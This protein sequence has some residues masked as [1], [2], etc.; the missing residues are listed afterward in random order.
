MGYSTGGHGKARSLDVLSHPQ[1]HRPAPRVTLRYYSI[2]LVSLPVSIGRGFA[3]AD[4]A[5]SFRSIESRDQLAQYCGVPLHTL[6]MF[7]YADHISFYRD[8]FVQK[9][10]GLGRRRIS[11]PVASLKRIQRTIMGG[12]KESYRPLS[13]VYG[14]VD[15][16]NV[17]QN[18]LMH[19]KKK[20][21][22]TLDLEDFFPSITS[23]RVYGL[24]NKFLGFNSE[25]SSTLTGLV[26]H[27]GVLPQGAPTSPIISN[28]ICYKMDKALL[29]YCAAH[30][31]TYSRYADDLIFSST[32]SYSM[33]CLL[34]RSE[35]RPASLSA[36][37]VETITNNGFKINQNKTHIAN[38]GSRQLVNGIVVNVK[39]NMLRSEYRS[40]RAMFHIWEKCGYFQAVKKYLRAKPQYRDKLLFDGEI[41]S[42]S[43]FIRHI[44]GRLDYYSLVVGSNGRP[45][46]PMIKLWTMFYLQTGEKVPYVT[47]EMSS[48]LITYVYD[49]VAPSSGEIATCG[50]DASAVLCRGFILTCRHCIPQDHTDA[51]GNPVQVEIRLPN[52][53]GASVNSGSFKSY[54]GFDF[55]YA[56]LNGCDIQQVNLVNLDYCLQPGE[57]VTAVGYAG[58]RVSPYRVNAA[59]RPDTHKDGELTVDRAFIKGMSGGPVFNSRHELIGIVTQGSSESS[60]ARDGKFLSFKTLRELEPFT[61]F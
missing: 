42:E 49:S 23:R 6:T 48:A 10:N 43:V 30:H 40:I 3:V 34:D 29:N 39:C 57:E 25:V 16:K 4:R 21:V 45:S 46:D 24:F 8:W 51:Y 54:C 55:A 44:R 26:T 7:A 35:G 9:R 28:M 12:L 53:K 61:H 18:A 27:E 58:G 13:C 11:S 60:Y 5:I 15:N 41:V 2:R 50:A 52:G 20:T 47:Y 31:L 56:P 37:L 36:F 14:Y 22:L 1:K 38:Q 32:S 33:A 17:A 59:V 19:T